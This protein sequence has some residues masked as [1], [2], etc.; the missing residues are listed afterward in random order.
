MCQTLAHSDVLKEKIIG[1]CIYSFFH[2]LHF[3]QSVCST[4]EV[5]MQFC[6][7]KTHS[8]SKV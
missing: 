3:G 4:E 2:N 1:K 6:S 5:N 8:S 7:V